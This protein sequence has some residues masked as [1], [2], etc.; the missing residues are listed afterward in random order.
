MKYEGDHLSHVTLAH[1]VV[2]HW[3]GDLFT[4]NNWDIICL[5]VE[6]SLSEKQQLCCR[7]A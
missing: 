2:H 7:R 6:A 1:E 3:L 4:I 5:Q